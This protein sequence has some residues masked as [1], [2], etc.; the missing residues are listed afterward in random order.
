MVSGFAARLL[1]I[2]M[3]S[4]FFARLCLLVAAI[5][6]IVI[7]VYNSWF[8]QFWDA[9]KHMLGSGMDMSWMLSKQFKLTAA[10]KIFMNSLNG[11][12]EL[13]TFAIIRSFWVW[14]L[15]PLV[16][17]YIILFD[18]KD[19]EGKEFIQ[20][21]QYINPEQL[22]FLSH[23]FS[24]ATLFKAMKLKKCIPL[25]Q[26][27]LPVTEEPKQTFVVGKPGV[28]KTNLFNQVIRKIRVRK[29]KGVIHD[30]K[31]DYV[32]KF[33][34][35]S[36][37]D[38]LFNP[39]DMRSVGWCL[40]NDC[41]SVMDIESFAHGLIPEAAPGGDPFWNNAARDIFTGILRYC[42]AN[43]KTTNKDIW[44][45]VILPNSYLLTILSTTKGGEAGAKHLADPYGKTAGSIMSNLMQYVKIFDYMS[46]MEG[47][48]SITEWVTNKSMSGTIFITNYA[49]LQN[50]LKPIISLF[51]QTVGRVLL[52]QRD[53]PYRR[54]FFFLDEFGQLPNMAT[55]QN[56]M[57]GSRSKGGVVFIG[58]QDIGQIDKLYKK[59]LRTTILNSASN[60]IVFNCKDH[61]TAKFFS[62]D[63]GEIEYY[64]N[65][66]T[67][68]L[69]MSDGDRVN[70]SRQRRKEPLV[71][72]EDIQSLP[73]LSAFVS[74]GH[75]DV[76]MSKWKYMKLKT[77]AEAF[78]QR[79]DLDL[80][81]AVDVDLNF[82]PVENMP[83]VVPQQQIDITEIPD[84][85]N[86][87]TGDDFDEFSGYA[88]SEG[89]NEP[90]DSTVKNR[91]F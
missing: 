19:D 43:R 81:N 25:G 31:G 69:S 37:G 66:S 53:D 62:V 78:I 46:S 55:I 63:I 20:G 7:L 71:T 85:G 75:H 5:Q 73:D 44:E 59:E 41:K 4:K 52:S 34:D 54:L 33:Y 14:L 56:L 45:T 83:E 9:T 88:T 48:F 23:T 29:Q 67:K 3:F 10:A 58:V 50:T 27:Y 76:T 39:L 6:I 64:E 2:K 15:I 47:N 26:V 60:R 40:F 79:P 91:I 16:M 74:I 72:P 17:T 21:R 12:V 87:G 42:H 49:N 30:Y 90:G 82:T 32:E 86:N 89:E 11:F 22:N 13:Q 65:T 38:I 68:S 61:E 57:T 80:V 24:K 70:T 18:E 84:N 51:I 36:K 28:G 77:K 8:N 35:E 1:Q